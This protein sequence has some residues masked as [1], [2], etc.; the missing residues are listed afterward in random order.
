V[1]DVFDAVDAIVVPSI[2]LENAPLVIF[3]ALQARVPVVTADV[4][5]MSELVADG[6]N[7]VLFRHRDVSSLADALQ[8]VLADPAAAAVLGNHGPLQ[9]VS[10]PSVEQHAAALAALYE[11]L[12]GEG[13]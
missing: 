4:G 9:G 11:S 13:N 3:E 2:W 6:I 5:G 1:R 10:V 8:R 7:G 12:P